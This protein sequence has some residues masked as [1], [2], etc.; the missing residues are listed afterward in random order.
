MS[1][2]E[3][4]VCYWT[5]DEIRGSTARDSISGNN[6]TLNGNHLWRPSGGKINGF[7]KNSV[8]R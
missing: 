6:G 7:G 4:Y 1:N 3:N 5:L 2:G 8:G